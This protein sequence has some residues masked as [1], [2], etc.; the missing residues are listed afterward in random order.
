MVSPRLQ[1]LLRFFGNSRL[2]VVE[3]HVGKQAIVAKG[4]SPR[5]GGPICQVGI[6]KLEWEAKQSW[7]ALCVTG[8]SRVD[9]IDQNRGEQKD[10]D[11]NHK[12]RRQLNDETF[13]RHPAGR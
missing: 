9:R 4:I 3:N 2:I 12:I 5:F 10:F 6:G 8:A 11:S 13:G 7:F 1:K